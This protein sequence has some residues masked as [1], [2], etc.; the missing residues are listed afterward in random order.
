MGKTDKGLAELIRKKTLDL[1]MTKEPEEISTR[2]IAKEC[3]V[4]ATSLYYHYKDKE[5]LFEA[6]KI[7]CLNHM[8]NFIAKRTAGPEKSGPIRDPSGGIYR[9]GLAAFRD[10]AFAN[11]RMAVL[12]M[13]RF[14]AN[15]GADRAELDKYYRSTYLAKTMLDRG[16]KAGQV[17]SSDTLLDANLCIAALWG[18]I[19]AVLLNRTD[20]KYWNKG[21]QFTNKMIDLLVSAL[22][23]GY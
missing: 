22:V 18:A 15:V 4:S 19:E 7:D 8:D 20:P 14:K 5:S 21:I 2:E 9:K 1:L 17:K 3:G 16:V 12:V 10:W 11:P 23:Q 13:G 6:V